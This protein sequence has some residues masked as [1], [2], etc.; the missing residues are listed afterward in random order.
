MI[1]TTS[2]AA[3][4]DIRFRRFIGILPSGKATGFD[5][6]ITSSNLVIPARE[7]EGFQHSVIWHWLNLLRR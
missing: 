4:D 7:M 3:C 2:P 5:S 1:I 6:R